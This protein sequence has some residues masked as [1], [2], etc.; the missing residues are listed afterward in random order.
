MCGVLGQ[1]EAGLEDGGGNGEG[2][3]GAEDA[4]EKWGVEDSA[5]YLDTRAP[6]PFQSSLSPVSFPPSNLK[7]DINHLE[8]R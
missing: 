1:G 6:N 7:K 5:V 4:E 8:A 3:W 2:D